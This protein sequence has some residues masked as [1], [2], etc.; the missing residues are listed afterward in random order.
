M[1]RRSIRKVTLSDA[2]QW[3][4]IEGET[5][6][7]GG[8]PVGS[9]SELLGLFYNIALAV[10]GKAKLVYPLGA[11]GH[12]AVQLA[13]PIILISALRQEVR[14]PVSRADYDQFIS[15]KIRPDEGYDQHI[16]FKNGFRTGTHAKF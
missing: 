9:I 16:G 13:N 2:G 3:D 12:N 6:E 7:L 11:N 15:A 5:Q 1:L 4:E 8:A 10:A 14:F